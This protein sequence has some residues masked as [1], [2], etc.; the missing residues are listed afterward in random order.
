MKENIKDLQDHAKKKKFSHSSMDTKLDLAMSQKVCTSCPNSKKIH[1]VSLAHLKLSPKNLD[2]FVF[3]FLWTLFSFHFLYANNVRILHMHFYP[4]F[5]C[6]RNLWAVP[7]FNYY[8][9]CLKKSDFTHFLVFFFLKI[10]VGQ[11]LIENNYFVKLL[12]V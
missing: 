8:I 11:K 7:Y 9:S 4:V 6:K 12:E 5:R 10:H 2:F 1:Y 3:T